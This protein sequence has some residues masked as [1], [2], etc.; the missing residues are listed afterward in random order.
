LGLGAKLYGV[1]P[2]LAVSGSLLLLVGL[3][4]CLLPSARDAN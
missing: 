1:Q 3:V 2:M 4:A